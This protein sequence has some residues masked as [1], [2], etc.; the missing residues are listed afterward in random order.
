MILYISR[1]WYV[2]LPML[3]QL[4]FTFPHRIELPRPITLVELLQSTFDGIH[5]IAS[6]L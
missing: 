1:I 6:R 2:F 3:S 4:T 5:G